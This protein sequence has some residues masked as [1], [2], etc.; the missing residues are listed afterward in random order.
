MKL[1][2]PRR[3]FLRSVAVGAGGLLL[4][5]CDRIAGHESVNSVLRMAEALTMGAQRAILS[6]QSLAR[7]FTE[8]DLSPVF[9][10][11]GTSMPDSEDYAALLA[12]KFANWRLEVGGLVDKPLSMSLADLKTPAVPDADHEA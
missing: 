1:V 11:N 5:A 10:S 6:D 3:H 2:L 4:G 7:E 9:R 8:A 12:G